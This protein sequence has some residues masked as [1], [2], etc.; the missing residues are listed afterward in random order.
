MKKTIV[1]AIICHCAMHS[2]G[3]NTNPW[4]S[5][6]SV[7]IGTTTPETMLHVHN[8]TSVTTVGSEVEAFRVANYNNNRSQFKFMYRRH[9]AGTD[10][11]GVATRLQ[12]ATDD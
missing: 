10:W 5:S 4:P 9:T 3:Q 11:L 8:N 12:F 2:I 1:L 6:G 7:G